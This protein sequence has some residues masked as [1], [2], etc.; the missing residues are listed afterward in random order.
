MT[1]YIF[2]VEFFVFF[3]AF[4]P[5]SL[6]S[7]MLQE[8]ITEQSKGIVVVPKWQAQPWYPIFNKLVCSECLY[9]GPSTD[10][11]K[12]YSSKQMFQ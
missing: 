6:I 3:Y 9:L 4:P 10:L 8:I 5:F 12:S 11:F 7:K 2:M 1:H